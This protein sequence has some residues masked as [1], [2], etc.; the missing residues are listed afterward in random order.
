M[1]GGDHRRR[2][3]VA[4]HV[5]GRAGHV[6]DLVLGEGPGHAGGQHEQDGFSDEEQIVRAMP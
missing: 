1:E 6:P 2:E 3:V 4:D 5:E